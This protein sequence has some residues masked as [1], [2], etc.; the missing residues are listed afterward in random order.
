M[1]SK[2]VAKSSPLLPFLFANWSEVKH[3]KI[4]QWLR[5]GAVNVNDHIITQHD[6][7]LQSGDV[8]SIRPQKAP[9]AGTQLPAGL[10]VVYED[11][12]LLIIVKP[13]N[14]LTVATENE[15]DKTAFHIMT[16]YI[17]ARGRSTHDRLWI[18]HRL[19]RETSGL[20][21][22][23]KSEKVKFWLQKNWARMEKRYLAVVE[24]IMPKVENTLS[25]FIDESQPHRV[26][27][28]DHATSKTRE[29]TTH[30]R[31]LS[32]SQ[33]RSLLEI[34]LETGRRHQIR[35]Q[36]AAAGCPIVGDKKYGAK[37]NPVKR[38]ALHANFL[39]LLHPKDERELFFESQLPESVARLA[40]AVKGGS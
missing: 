11:D 39:K 31:V 23:A 5:F 29:A 8:I 1:N 25:G 30:Y 35:A 14:L 32:E 3:T 18:V 15:R 37:T 13:V 24:G 7:V 40:P 2:I 19:D 28:S 38:I 10:S 9:P 34:T 16:D 26:F 33:A 27:V 20:L 22:L 4:K 12:E 6:Y 17:R 21:V 36:L